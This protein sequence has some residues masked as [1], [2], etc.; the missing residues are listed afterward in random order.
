M[1][2]ATFLSVTRACVIEKCGFRPNAVAKMET[3]GLGLQ[4]QFEILAG[5]L[6]GSAKNKRRKL[7]EKIL[8]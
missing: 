5:K 3:A 6:D 4:T 8:A 1:S 7:L 2:P